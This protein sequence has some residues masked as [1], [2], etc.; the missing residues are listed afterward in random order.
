MFDKQE[1]FEL[2]LEKSIVEQPIINDRLKYYL[3]KPVKELITLDEKPL[4][5]PRRERHRLY[6]LALM[7]VVYHYWNGKK[8]RAG[9]RG[10]RQIF[11]TRLS[12][13]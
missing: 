9:R 5:A 7:S 3:D 1:T 11:R 4:D 12:R 10:G 2:M 8:K 6:A 13:T